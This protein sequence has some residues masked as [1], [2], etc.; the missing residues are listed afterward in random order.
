MDKDA[1]YQYTFS[2][3]VWKYDGKGG[4]HFISAPQQL[5]SRISDDYGPKKRG[6]GSIPITVRTGQSTWQTSLF[7]DART[8]TYMMPLKSFVRKAESIAE[9]ETRIFTVMLRGVQFVEPVKK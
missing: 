3:Q 1:P 9:G 4:W 6:W 2:A 8:K 7:P 5:S